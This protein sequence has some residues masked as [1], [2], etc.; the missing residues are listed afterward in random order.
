[1]R[2]HSAVNSWLDIVGYIETDFLGNDA[3]NVFVST[4]SHTNRL[5]LAYADV[6]AGQL[7]FTAGQ[8]WSWMT[9][10]RKGLGPDPKTVFTTINDDA[11]IQVGLPFTRAAQARV[12]WHPTKEFAIGVGVENPDQFVGAG[13]VIYPFAFNAALGPQFDAANQTTVPNRY[14]DVVGKA[15][16]DTDI[17]DRHVHFEGAAMWRSFNSTN[18]PIGGAFFT[19]HSTTGWLVQAS[20]NVEVLERRRRD[21]VRTVEARAEIGYVCAW[22]EPGIGILPHH[23][24]QIPCS[25]IDRSKICQ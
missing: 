24:R 17:V 22:H 21:V 10:N 15:T 5:R 6:N 12:A 20:G 23:R 16:Y 14:P 4:N 25:R 2:A 11:G 9:P 8:A 3:T 18:V 1:V 13:E 19:D 7:E